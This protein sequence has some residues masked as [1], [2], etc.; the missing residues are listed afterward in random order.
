MRPAYPH[1]GA[2]YVCAML[3]R[4]HHDVEYIDMDIDGMNIASLL[5]HVSESG[6]QVVGLSCVT[7]IAPE[8]FKIAN[9]IKDR[10]KGI[11]TVM[12]GVHATIDP[13]NS[14]AVPGIDA[15]CIGEGEHTM[16]DLVDTLQRNGDLKGVH[17]IYFKKA[18]IVFKNPPRKVEQD[19]DNLPFP[20]FHLVKDPKKYSPPDAQKLPALPIITSR[21][22][23]GRCTYCCTKQI[24]GQRF[25]MRSIKN[26]LEELDVFVDRYGA[27]EAH[28][29]DDNL[30]SNKKRFL[31]LCNALKKRNY[32]LNFET[33][34]GIRADSVDEEILNAL[35]GISINNI[36]FGVES[37]DDD[38]LKIIKKG[39]TKDQV[40]RA[41]KLAKD[42]EFTTWG[43]FVIGFYGDTPKTI[44]RTLDFSLELDPDFAKY[45]ILKPYPGSEIF[46]QLR[47]EGLIDSLDY[48]RY[49][50][51]TN[52]VHHLPDVSAHE[53]IK[54]QKKAYRSFYLRPKKILNLLARIGSWTQFKL[55]VNG[56]GLV[57]SRMLRPS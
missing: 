23:Y 27:R 36:G 42:L 56:A 18:G 1:Y 10:F 31:E 19:L 2:L 40:R 25:R 3:E 12:G 13:D 45:F 35:R 55:T 8:G 47:N 51:Y 54:W 44:Q 26:V 15:V 21:G 20:A 14:V 6:P 5:D 24:L 50:L 9:A 16:R 52:P 53:L 28:F 32:P 30:S 41:M 39:I 34:N 49:G 29:L 17:G 48:S 4:D 22:C 46:E 57:L 7:P 38:I 33:S 37:G 43:F 11:F